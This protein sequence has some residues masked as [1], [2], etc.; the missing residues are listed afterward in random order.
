MRR[1]NGRTVKPKLDETINLIDDDMYR[2]RRII[3]RS[4]RIK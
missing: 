2:H 4:A 3:T 1:Y